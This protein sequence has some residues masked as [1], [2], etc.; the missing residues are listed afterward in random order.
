MS[1]LQRRVDF[2]HMDGGQALICPAVV[3]QHMLC[4]MLLSHGVNSR[5]A[6]YLLTALA[7]KFIDTAHVRNCAS[8]WK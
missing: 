5:A 6:A 8:V 3:E 4:K 2:E 1:R 7:A